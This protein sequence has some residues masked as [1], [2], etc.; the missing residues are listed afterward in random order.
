MAAVAGDRG[1]TCEGL[2]VP[3]KPLCVVRTAMR[4]E[5]GGKRSRMKAA[6]AAGVANAEERRVGGMGSQKASPDLDGRR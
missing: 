2:T 4:D 5:A 3:W 6:V 1:R